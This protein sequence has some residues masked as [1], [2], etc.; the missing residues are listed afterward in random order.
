MLLIVAHIPPSSLLQR[1]APPA[2]SERRPGSVMPAPTFNPT[3]CADRPD[4]ARALPLL[5][6]ADDVAEATTPDSDTGASMLP[7]EAG[8]HKP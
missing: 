2:R 7:V 5:I 4:G 3:T 1:P 8:N 6:V